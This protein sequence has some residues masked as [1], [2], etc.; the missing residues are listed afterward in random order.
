M[1]S[2]IQQNEQIYDNLW[3]G[4]GLE[5][6]LHAINDVLR[7]RVQRMN[8]R[9]PQARGDLIHQLHRDGKVVS[10][11]YEG[12]DVLLSAIVPKPVRHL[13]ETYE[14]GEVPNGS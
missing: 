12:N 4:T 14:V 11:A 9:I 13:F 7:D 2:A 3:A 6:L 8:L 5:E 10:E 1:N